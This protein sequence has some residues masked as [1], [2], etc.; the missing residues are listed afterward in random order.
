MSTLYQGFAS[1]IQDVDMATA[2]TN[3]SENQTAL[4]AA[5]EVT[6]QMGQLSL[7]NYVDPS[8]TGTA[9]S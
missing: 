8:S 3:L 7:L 9:S 4:Q 1:D 5:L 2:S 6:S